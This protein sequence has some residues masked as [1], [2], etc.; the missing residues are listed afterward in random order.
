MV[1]DA[2]SDNPV[3]EIN[4]A[5][6]I[7]T[8]TCG[9]KLGIRAIKENTINKIGT[10]NGRSINYARRQTN[11]GLKENHGRNSINNNP[12]GSSERIWICNIWLLHFRRLHHCGIWVMT[13]M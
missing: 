4:Q 10:W 7:A 5:N 2:N 6:P 13:C 1:I 9:D 3:N 12:M 8:R 11:L